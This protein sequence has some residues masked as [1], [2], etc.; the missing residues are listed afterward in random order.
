MRLTNTLFHVVCRQRRCAIQFGQITKRG[1]VQ[2]QERMTFLIRFLFSL[3]RFQG[4]FSQVLVMFAFLLFFTIDYNGVKQVVGGTASFWCTFNALAF[5]EAF[6]RRGMHGRRDRHELRLNGHN[7]DAL[8][9]EKVLQRVLDTGIDL[10]RGWK[11]LVN[12][13]SNFHSRRMCRNIWRRPFKSNNYPSLFAHEMLYL[14]LS[15]IY[16]NLNSMINK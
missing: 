13:M 9:V 8:V 7:C 14:P 5:E 15:L 16:E 3:L 4:D 2:T 12:K 11:S 6:I 1:H 10:Q